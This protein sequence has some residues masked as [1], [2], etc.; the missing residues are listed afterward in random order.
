MSDKLTVRFQEYERYDI[1]CDQEMVTLMAVTPRGSFIAEVA[2]EPR[3][4]LRER[5]KEFQ[6]YVID[7]M[8]LGHDPHE[9]SFG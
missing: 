7:E 3:K 1:K 2:A 5:R 4:K 9:V 8:V 6:E